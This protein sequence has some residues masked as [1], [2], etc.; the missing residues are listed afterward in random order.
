MYV[1]YINCGNTHRH[2]RK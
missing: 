2:R 1:Y